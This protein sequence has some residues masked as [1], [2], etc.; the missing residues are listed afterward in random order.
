MTNYKYYV[1]DVLCFICEQIYR[2]LANHLECAVRQVVRVTTELGED[3]EVTRRFFRAYGFDEAYLS[4][5]RVL[6][7]KA[8]L[9]LFIYSGDRRLPNAPHQIT[10]CHNSDLKYAVSSRTTCWKSVAQKR[11][12]CGFMVS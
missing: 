4:L 10:D 9:R 5:D 3:D 7:W 6:H 11:N 2:S 12:G 1:S 8:G